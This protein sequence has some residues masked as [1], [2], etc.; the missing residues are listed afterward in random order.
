MESH[1]IV[2]SPWTSLLFEKAAIGMHSSLNGYKVSTESR[3]PIHSL[4]M[5]LSSRK[6]CAL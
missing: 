5:L 2:A 6:N 1:E 3:K 4:R